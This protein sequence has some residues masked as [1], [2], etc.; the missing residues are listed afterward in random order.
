MSKNN[1]NSLIPA[2]PST[3]HWLRPAQ[4]PFY[5]GLGRSTIYSLMK[6]GLIKSVSV[7]KKNTI[8][9]ARLISSASIDEFLCTLQKQQEREEVK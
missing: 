3:P 6:R 7:T 5:Y 9:G 8:R 1:S 4:V 2:K